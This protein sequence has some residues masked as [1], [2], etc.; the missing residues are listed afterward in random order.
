M[1]EESNEGR[2]KYTGGQNDRVCEP[3]EPPGPLA[4]HPGASSR[5]SPLQATPPASSRPSH[6]ELLASASCPVPEQPSAHSGTV[7]VPPGTGESNLP[8]TEGGISLPGTRRC[9]QPGAPAGVAVT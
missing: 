6:S 7:T 4:V 8:G 9:L 1:N 5:W 3:G 2:N